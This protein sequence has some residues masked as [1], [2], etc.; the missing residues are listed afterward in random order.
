MRVKTIVRYELK[1]VITRQ[2]RDGLMDDLLSRMTPDQYGDVL[3]NYTITSLYYDTKNYDAYW[4]KI[5][6]EKLRRKVRVRTYGEQTVQPETRC[7]LEIKQRQNKTLTKKRVCLPYQDAIALDELESAARAHNL[8]ASDRAITDEV[9]YLARVRDL[10]PS[11][12][13]RYNRLALNGDAL[14]PDLRVTFDTEL[15][16]RTHDLSLLSTGFADDVYFLPPDACILEVKANHSVP[17]WLAQLLNKHRCTMQRISKY[18]TA[19]ERCG[20]LLARQ[21]ITL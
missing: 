21:Q 10:R 4:E 17:Y 12:V 2:Q 11:C 6:G 20:V 5:E 13:V 19:L 7:F 9:E 15:R 16:G 18:C 14:S 1:Y 8:S 3:G